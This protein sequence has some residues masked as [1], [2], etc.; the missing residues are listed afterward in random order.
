LN[1]GTSKIVPLKELAARVSRREL[2]FLALGG[3]FLHRDPFAF[4]RELIRQGRTNLK[5]IKQ[6]PGYGI[7]ILCRA[8]SLGRDRA[9]IGCVP[10]FLL[11]PLAILM[12]PRTI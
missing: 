4:M 10:F 7:D 9:G 2:N 3:S 8:G 12:R 11:R 1:S 5:V 6:S